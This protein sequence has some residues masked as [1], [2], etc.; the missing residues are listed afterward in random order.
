MQ[1]NT[2]NTNIYT[3]DEINHFNALAQSI[4]MFNCKESQ[5][6][7]INSQLIKEGD[8]FIALKEYTNVPA[9]NYI[10]DALNNGASAIIT[11]HIPKEALAILDPEVIKQKIL[12]VEDPLETLVDIAKYKRYILSITNKT[13]IV[14]VTGSIGKT[15]LKRYFNKCSGIYTN[16]GNLNNHIGLPLS[17]ASVPMDSKIAAFELGMNNVREINH[18]AQI[19]KPEI[20]IITS[21]SDAHIGILKS[22]IQIMQEKLSIV[23]SLIGKKILILSK[24]I[25]YYEYMR[26][27]AIKHE[28]QIFTF[29]YSTDNDSVSDC[30]I[31]SYKLE[32]NERYNDPEVYYQVF[33]NNKNK[34]AIINGNKNQIQYS[35]KIDNFII[36]KIKLVIFGVNINVTTRYIPKHIVQTLLAGILCDSIITC[37]QDI[38]NQNYFD[39]FD[40]RNYVINYI[41]KNQNIND[42]IYKIDINQNFI[43]SSSNDLAHDL[44]EEYSKFNIT[45][46]IVQNIILHSELEKMINTKFNQYTI[47][48]GRGNLLL[49]DN[50]FHANNCV[51][52]NDSYNASFASMK[53]SIESFD[54]LHQEWQENNKNKIYRKVL[55]LADMLELG[56]FAQEMHKNLVDVILNA[57]P[58]LVILCG[59]A[60]KYTFDYLKEL[61]SNNNIE[62]YYFENTE[63]IDLILQDNDFIL[64]KGSKGTGLHKILI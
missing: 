53:A 60:I 44:S 47:E 59:E 38:Y 39:Y 6:F 5:N 20:A 37:M 56:D 50:F 28:C 17:L 49:L 29:D 25:A 57:T 34:K 19:L 46:N 31:A 36:I 30:Y 35:T 1:N 52:I 13:I 40:L 7:Q 33:L 62:Y 9:S 32:Y 15:S 55:F 27:Y 11:H 21:V 16:I 3:N 12:L 43:T 41:Q 24:N 51:L 23:N 48:N 58:D 64:L 22:K 26:N 42:G 4:T 61:N 2:N 14:G 45:K 54:N 8:V 63:A 10:L 18:L